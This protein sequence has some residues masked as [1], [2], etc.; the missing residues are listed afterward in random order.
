MCPFYDS[1]KTCLLV[2]S[3]QE[4]TNRNKTRR[5]KRQASDTTMDNC[6]RYVEK[7]GVDKTENVYPQA[8]MYRTHTGFSAN[9][10]SA[11]RPTLRT[12]LPHPDGVHRRLDVVHAVADGERLGFEADRAA[13]GGGGPRGVD[14][15]VDR[16]GPRLVVQVQELRRVR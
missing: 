12:H 6:V 4:Q 16:L 13:V 9:R 7:I 1:A 11:Q 3:D 14:V 15:H 2:H 5:T 8:S 10:T